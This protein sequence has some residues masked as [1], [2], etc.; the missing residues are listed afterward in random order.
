MHQNDTPLKTKIVYQYDSASFRL[1]IYQIQVDYLNWISPGISPVLQQH[2]GHPV[3]VVGGGDVEGRA[4]LDVPGL[5]KKRK[6][7]RRD[8]F[9]ISNRQMAMA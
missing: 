6:N 4:V 3:V 5:K 2:R 9:T 7:R 8:V 1:L